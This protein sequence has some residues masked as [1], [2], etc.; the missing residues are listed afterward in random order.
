MAGMFDSR[1]VLE[2]Q[3]ANDIVDVI[4]EHVSLKKKGREMVGLC[5]FHDD[6]KPS[7]NVNSVKQI[8]KCFAC[9]AG[10]DVFKFVQMRENLTFPQAIERLADRA[11]IKIQKLKTRNPKPGTVDVD[12]NALA[13][14]NAWAAKYFCKNLQD[15]KKGKY[16]RDYL[17]QRKIKP[18]SVKKWQLGLAVDLQDDLIKAAA[19]NKVPAKLLEQAGL[20]TGR[21]QDKFVNRL[22]FTI[23]DVTGRV[24]GFG[25]RTLNETGAKYINSPTT[26]LFDKSNSLYG[27]EQAR[28]E[29][30]STG[31]AVVVEGY[32]DCI[33]AHQ[34]GCCNVVATLGT[35]LTAGH[36]RILR[37]YAKKVV[38]IFDS[39][40]AGVEAANR[41]LDVCLSQRIDIK[42]ASVPEGKDPCDFLLA[43]GKEGFEG[44]IR[45]AVDVFKFKWDRLKEKFDKDDTLAGKR[46]AI[47]EYLET[48]ATGLLAGNV[49][50]LD[51]G[52][53]VNQISRIVGLDSKRINAELNVRL[54]R[55]ARTANRSAENRQ[56][57]RIDYGRGRFAA[58]QRE[59]LE[60]LLNEPELFETVRGKIAAESFD[61]PILGQIAEILFE[62]LDK[63]TETSLR[64]I[65]AGTESVQLGNCIMELAQA[66][67]EKGNYQARL[68]GAL[69]TV[70]RYRGQEQDESFETV[71]QQRQYLRRFSEK[72]GRENPHS[73]GMV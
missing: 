33:M 8:F 19:A 4:S 26:V 37:R 24:I 14:V 43:A 39:D 44:L 6:H 11:G 16:A 41:A 45:D 54:K 10:G 20:T 64:E 5:P 38:L 28:H 67:E 42:I 23:T 2:V 7:M 46:A 13:R 62:R 63:N 52:L 50:D 34:F 58:A 68:A 22:M 59:V 32:T 25:G 15:T 60:I 1:I 53:R 29:I 40:V 61:V 47:E 72:N 12:P 66:G 56:V 9:G 27:L 31:T 18:E 65:L 21:N 71:E 70:E 57:R 30:V 55:A 51:C 3:Q 35:S 17:A 48:V 49:S 69:D 36:G 73:I